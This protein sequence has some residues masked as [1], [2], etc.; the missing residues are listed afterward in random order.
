MA[1]KN[2]NQ[3]N[4]E[5]VAER[6]IEVLDQKKAIEAMEKELKVELLKR[7]ISPIEFPKLGK[8]VLLKEGRMLQEFDLPKLFRKIGDAVLPF[9]KVQAGLVADIEDPDLL[10]TFNKCSTYKQGEQTVGVEKLK[11]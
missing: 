4:D 11:G 3:M 9:C 2:L 8:K 7:K 1:I 10:V 5:T 6:L